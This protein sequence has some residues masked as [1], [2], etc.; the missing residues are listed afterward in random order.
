VK[1]LH[2]DIIL[3]LAAFCQYAIVLL[4]VADS[5]WMTA[6]VSLPQNSTNVR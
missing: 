5:T 1:I 2:I 4:D 6:F 3:I